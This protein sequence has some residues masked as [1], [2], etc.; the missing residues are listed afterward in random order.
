MAFGAPSLGNIS[1]STFS[2]IG[3]AA[4]DLLSSKLQASGLRITAEGT[5]LQAEGNRV[6][7]ENY[8]LA[9]QLAL[10]NEEFTKQSVAVQ[11]TMAD[12]QIQMSMGETTS[13]VAGS[14]FQLGGSALDILR[15]SAQQG[16]LQKQLVGQ[17]GLITEVSQ[18]EQ[19]QSFKNLQ[20]YANTAAATETAIAGQQDQL[21]KTTEKYGKINA[22]IK[23]ASAIASIFIH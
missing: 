14:G 22:S 8:G 18:E 7:G 5:R 9:S 11:Q 13:E 23:A 17:Q 12:R 21:A 16:A 1:N 15:S 10:T 6:E 2:N 20:G 19:A 4:S 3:G